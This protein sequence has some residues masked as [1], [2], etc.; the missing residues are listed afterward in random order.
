MENKSLITNVCSDE[1]IFNE[2]AE[3]PID[4]EFTLPDYLPDINRILKCKAVSRI[5][6]KG[7]NGS[8]ISV[9]GCVTVTIIYSD[10]ENCLY[11]YEYQYPFNKKFDMTDNVEGAT[12]CCKTRCEYINCRA[13]TGRKIDIHGAAG[14][15]L[16]VKTKNN[17]EI[18]T[19]YDDENIELNRCSIPATSPMGYS[20][21]YVILEDEIELGN[22]QPSIKSLLRYDLNASISE[23]KIVKEKCV[24][25]GNAVLNA[26]YCTCDNVLQIFRHSIPF[27][28]LIEIEG[29][30]ENCE[31]DSKVEVAYLELKPKVSSNGDSKS[32]LL[33]AK[34]LLKVEAYC[35]NDIEVIT[36]AFSRKYYTDIN[37]KNITLNK[38]YKSINETFNCK[39]NIE[40]TD[41]ISNVADMWCDIQNC[42]QRIEDQNLFVSG[43]VCIGIIAYNEENTP[44]YY[45]KNI[46]FEYKYTFTDYINDKF[47]C[48]LQLE[49]LSSNYTLIG[50]GSIEIR[51]ELSVNA[52]I[53]I[54]KDISL[55]C[56]LDVDTNKQIEPKNNGSL[57]IY[58]ASKGESVW[59]I[60]R[61]YS[62]SIKEI[63]QLNNL[64]D[65]YIQNKKMLLVPVI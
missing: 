21:K 6:S 31:C 9:D 58:Y 46:D 19:D 14:I 48:D 1:V 5:S 22:G 12:V 61:H 49:I 40:L 18:L 3:Q 52:A 43:V 4:I 45:E 34:L 32:L 23:C 62:A 24:I 11:S 15:Y 55:I 27:S 7:L 41:N 65:D 29:I 25:K 8:S 2:N 10:S 16:K 54:K 63:K 28:Q 42:T 38:L 37:K 47:F 20:E 50:N 36:D 30:N 17:C 59:E 39:K 26:L 56:K 53:Y 51:I 44:S 33:T 64:N 35:N 57:V 13:V 60:A